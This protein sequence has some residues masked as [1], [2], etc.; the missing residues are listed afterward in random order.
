[1]NSALFIS[2]ILFHHII[3]HNSTGKQREKG[4]RD[5]EQTQEKIEEERRARRWEESSL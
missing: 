1:M 3:S 4:K 5:T 2:H